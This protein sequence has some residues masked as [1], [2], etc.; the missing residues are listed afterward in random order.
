M[1]TSPVILMYHGIISSRADIP[2]DREAGADLY[3]LSAQKFREQMELIKDR[4][5]RP[6]RIEDMAVYDS[7][8]II[9]TF[10]D[11]EMNNFSNAYPVLKECGFPAYFFVTTNRIGQKGYMGWKEL[12]ILSKSGMII[13]SHGLTHRILTDLSEDELRTEILESKTNLEKHLNCVAH[14][15]SVPRGFYNDD[16]VNIAKDVKYRRLFVSQR[17]TGHGDYCLPRVAVKSNWNLER[18][19][20]ALAGKTPVRERI[21][22][23]VKNAAKGVLGGAGYDRLR[24]FLISKTSG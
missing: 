16:A 19:Q 11:G 1:K 3:D 15:F 21:F 7:R 12:E 6:S 24:G 23:G 14:Y 5:Y 9:I 13:G 22:E 17:L 20:M 18:F 4:G 8:R 2:P 10:D